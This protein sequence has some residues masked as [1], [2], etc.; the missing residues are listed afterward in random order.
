M[1]CR[2]PALRRAGNG[3]A[4]SPLPLS[5]AYLEPPRSAAAVAAA[6]GGEEVLDADDAN[7]R[8][9]REAPEAALEPPQGAEPE[10]LPAPGAELRFK[11]RGESVGGVTD[12][13]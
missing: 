8:V 5:Y 10:P 9:R 11:A 12:G 2:P 3:V 6:L 1:A 4:E 7:A 13:Y